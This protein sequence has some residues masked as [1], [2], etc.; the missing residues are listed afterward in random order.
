MRTVLIALAITTN[1]MYAAPALSIDREF[2][3]PDGT[4][5]K[6]SVKGD[7]YLGW[8]ESE[9]G[10]I[11]LLNNRSGAYEF[12]IIDQDELVS[13]GI[14]YKKL[15]KSAREATLS[16]EDLYRLWRKKREELSY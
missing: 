14:T 12:A 2:V 5:F 8:I 3:Q 4:S 10:E 11:L 16:K 1:M 6:A 9:G 15:S 7:E 13:S